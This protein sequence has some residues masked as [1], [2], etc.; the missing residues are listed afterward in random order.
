MPHDAKGRLLQA[1]DEVLIRATVKEVFPNPDY[2]NLTVV[3]HVPMDEEQ[4][5]HHITLNARQVERVEA[6][7]AVG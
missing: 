7:Q 1:G 6:E 3:T 2:C 4:G 5:D